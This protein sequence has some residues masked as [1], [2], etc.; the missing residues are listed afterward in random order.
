MAGGAVLAT[1]YAASCTSAQENP[2]TDQ[3]KSPQ[4]QP[5]QAAALKGSMTEYKSGDLVIPAYFARSEKGKRASAV[6]VI[7]EVF[8]L[9]DHIKSIADRI[10]DAGFHALAPNFF[11]R[12]S[13][14]P[15]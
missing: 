4:P 9:N 5:A 7:H 2:K 6:L 10:A 11:V 13:E 12:A 3:G 15:P 1:A 14:P 8:G